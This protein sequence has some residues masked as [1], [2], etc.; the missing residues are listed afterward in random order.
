MKSNRTPFSD[1]CELLTTETVIDADGY[2]TQ[3]EIAVQVFCSVNTGVVRSEYYE[4]MKAGLQLSVTIEI[5]EE[6]YNGAQHIRF[7]G[8]KYKV[9]RTFP[10]GHGTIEITCS[11]VKR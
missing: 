1:V 10:T 3:T 9:G 5:W 11:E 2:E 7:D 8:K 6:E 4:A